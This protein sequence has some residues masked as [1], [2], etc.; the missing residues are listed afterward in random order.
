MSNFKISKQT[1]AEKDEFLMECFHDTGLIKSLIQSNFSIISGRKGTGK[2]ALARY[3]EQNSKSYGVD[4][5]IRISVRNISLGLDENKKD[6]VNSILF[7][8]IIKIIQKLLEENF[9]T[10]TA[11]EHW[12]NFLIQNNLQNVS[13]Y[14]TFF[15]SKKEN[16]TGFSISGLISSFFV[17]A[18]GKA[19]AED[20]STFSRTEISNTPSSLIEALRQSFP[21]SKTL[22]VFLDDITDYLDISEETRVN[23]EILILQ[24][25]LLKL[26]LFNST[27]ADSNKRLR[28][29]SL[30]REDLFEYMEGSNVNKL[31]RDSLNLEWS[32]AD[33]ASLLIKRLPFYENNLEESL[34]NPK[35]A[36]RKEFPDAIFHESLKDF[37]T[38]RYTT[39]FYA[40]MVAVSFNRPRDFLMFCYAMRDRLSMKHEATFENID[41]AEIEYSDYF[42]SELR[43]ELFLASRILGFKADQEKVNQLI[44]VLSK[45]NGFNSSELRTDLGQYLGEKTS[46]LGRKKIEAFIDELWWYGVIGFK[47]EKDQLINFRYI[48]G[49]NPFLIAKIKNYIL[50]LHRGL[51]WFT[52]KRKKNKTV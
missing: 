26:E 3:L 7:F 23:K 6:H 19:N 14:E 46:K 25:L 49:R 35:E 31:K 36:I 9:F 21:E 13:D 52:Q 16:K 28:F 24:D 8:V 20:G 1:E 2:T 48:T 37:D 41:A 22:L 40:Y 5:V 51:W 42:S 29:I 10:G 4:C 30:V 18:E 17:K 12:V 45:K 11:K 43:D 27:F 50:F 38:N 47:E 33:F 39:N 34:K 44:D 32:E 15:E